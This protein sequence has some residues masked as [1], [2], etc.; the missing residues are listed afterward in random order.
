MKKVWPKSQSCIYCK[1]GKCNFNF[2]TK[3]EL[4]YDFSQCFNVKYQK[5]TCLFFAILPSFPFLQISC[6]T[7]FGPANVTCH[8]LS[9][10]LQCLILVDAGKSL[11]DLGDLATIHWKESESKMENGALKT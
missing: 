8:L 4:C 2:T 6:G 10:S 5:Y 9:Y 1:Q 3:G 11:Q 7:S